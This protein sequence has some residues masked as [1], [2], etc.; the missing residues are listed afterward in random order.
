M[1]SI[2]KA[3]SAGLVGPAASEL[4][5]RIA[6]AQT[7]PLTGSATC[8]ATGT[9]V[10]FVG[11]LELLRAL[12]DLVESERQKIEL[13]RAPRLAVVEPARGDRDR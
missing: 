1:C 2:L 3:D 9:P 11:W 8:P 5:I 13:N 12:A 6:I 10:P 7:E 4:V